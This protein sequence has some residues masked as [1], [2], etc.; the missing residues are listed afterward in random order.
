VFTNDYPTWS[1]GLTVNYALG[2]SS[3][4]ASFARAEVERRQATERIASLRV[5]AAETVRR[6]GRQVRSTQER[7]VAARASAALAQERLTAEQRRFEVGL[8]T[9]FLV[10]QAQRDLAEAE[11]TVLQTLLEHQSA[12]VNFEAVQFAAPLVAGDTIGMRGASVVLLPPA[13]PRGIFRAG[14]PAGF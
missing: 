8:S 9:T 3:E 5:Q 12:I 2:R 4:A 1:V 10:T 6:A 14:A 7:I 11:V 13:A